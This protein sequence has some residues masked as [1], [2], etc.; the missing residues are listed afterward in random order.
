MQKRNRLLMSPVRLDS[1]V[2]HN[3][4]RECLDTAGRAC[5]RMSNSLEIE[6][7]PSRIDRT[8]SPNATRYERRLLTD[9]QETFTAGYDW[10]G[11]PLH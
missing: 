7:D 1:D 2:A 10:G 4:A 5:V 9:G 8:R 3:L 6:R 11:W